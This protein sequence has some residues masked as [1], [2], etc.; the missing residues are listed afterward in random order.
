VQRYFF[1]LNYLREY[2]IDEEGTELPDLEAA[3]SEARQIIRELAASFIKSRRQFTMQS[4]RICDDAGA[5][6]AEV[7]VPEALNEVL[8]SHIVIPWKPDR[9]A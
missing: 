4:V 9:H 3:R 5:P 2:V 6:L 8:A 7:L 1:N